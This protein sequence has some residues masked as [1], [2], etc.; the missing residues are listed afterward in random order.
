MHAFPH[1][2]ISLM[3]CLVSFEILYYGGLLDHNILAHSWVTRAMLTHAHPASTITAIRDEELMHLGQELHIPAFC[4][5]LAKRSD[6][7]R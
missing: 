4:C 3:Y 6:Y 1:S 7:R 5:L 2:Y